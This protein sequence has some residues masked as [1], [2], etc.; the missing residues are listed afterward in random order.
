VSEVNEECVFRIYAN[1]LAIW[2]EIIQW[3][4]E[5]KTKKF[6]EKDRVRL[7]EKVTS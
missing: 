2:E 4:S 1:F 7:S 6:W 5:R 3:T